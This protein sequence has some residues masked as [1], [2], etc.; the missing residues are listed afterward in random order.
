MAIGLESA[1]MTAISNLDA[2]YAANPNGD[3]NQMKA[4]ALATFQGLLDDN[5]NILDLAANSGDP[6]IMVSD[7]S[8][9]VTMVNNA[10]AYIQSVLDAEGDILTGS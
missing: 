1:G 10:N 3:I 2:A 4:D 7:P 8:V 5:S 9:F 6:T